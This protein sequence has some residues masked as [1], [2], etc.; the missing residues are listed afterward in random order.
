[1]SLAFAKELKEDFITFS[2]PQKEILYLIFDALYHQELVRMLQANQQYSYDIKESERFRKGK[3]GHQ[4][5][6]LYIVLDIVAN[7]ERMKNL[8]DLVYYYLINEHKEWERIRRNTSLVGEAGILPSLNRADMP[9]E[10]IFDAN[11]N[12]LGVLFKEKID[13]QEILR[14]TRLAELE[15]KVGGGGPETRGNH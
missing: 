7:D 15:E 4:Q 2:E 1:M 9:V 5:K 10:E 12:A 6:I 3:S 13:E 11:F 8:T 14:R